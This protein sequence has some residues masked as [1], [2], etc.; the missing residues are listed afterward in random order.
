DVGYGKTEVA[1]RAAARAVI[2]GG[3]VAILVPTTILAEQHL[4]TFSDRL[5]QFGFRI[6]SLSRFVKAQNQKKIIKQCSEGSVDIVI[7]THRL[8]SKDIGFKDLRLIII[9]EEQKFGVKHKEKL[10]KLRAEV[11]IL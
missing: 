3:Q 5:D 11:D 4:Q 9:D 6:K 7:G 2:S 1:I 10:K 8:F